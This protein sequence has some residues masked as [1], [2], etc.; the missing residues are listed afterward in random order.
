VS[1]SPAGLLFAGHETTVAA[2]DRGVVLRTG[3]LHDLPAPW[4]D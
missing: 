4:V 2:I 1:C 3:G